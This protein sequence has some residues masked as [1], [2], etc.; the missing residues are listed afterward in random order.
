MPTADLEWNC[1]LWVTAGDGEEQMER[2]ATAQATHGGPVADS[3]LAPIIRD[4]FQSLETATL[5]VQDIEAPKAR[6]PLFPTNVVW[7]LG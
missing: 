5:I 7:K 4:Y 6:K 1:K 2:C 3:H